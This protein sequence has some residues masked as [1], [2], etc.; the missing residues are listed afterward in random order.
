VDTASLY[1]IPIF[2]QAVI[3]A[4]LHD[5]TVLATASAVDELRAALDGSAAADPAIGELAARLQTPPANVPMP[6]SGPLDPRFLGLIPTRGC[7]LACRYCNFAAG[8]ASRQQMSPQI[9]KGAIDWYLPLKRERGHR[10][11]EIHFFGGEPFAASEVIDLA[12]P[13]ARQRAGELGIRVAFEVA[14]NGVFSE[15]RAA[16]VGSYFDTVILSFDGFAETQ[17]AHRPFAGGQGTAAVVARSAHILSESSADLYL[18]ACVTDQTV[19]Q[20]PAIARW[21]CETFRPT[22]VCFEPLHLSVEARQA[23]LIPPDPWDFAHFFMEAEKVLSDFGLRAIHASA[24]ID[25]QRVSFCPA[26]ED[27]VIVTPDGVI[28]SCYLLAKEWEAKGLDL[29]L[30]RLDEHGAVMLAGDDIARARE[31]TV[32]RKPACADCFCR[33]HCAG[34]CHVNHPRHDRSKAYDDRCIETRAISLFRLLHRLDQPALAARLASDRDA[35]RRAVL[36]PDDLL[37]ERAIA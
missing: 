25:A 14:T 36:S 15:A 33:W 9:V 23:G 20:M 18:R 12:V 31:Y 21:F 13:Y 10:R 2:D 17:N 32:W 26:G 11:A 3:H 22:G 8:T 28:N 19:T 27:T 29:W 1:L 7:N 34:G 37:L 4:P 30:G 24:D 16:W 6:R 5:V 35:L